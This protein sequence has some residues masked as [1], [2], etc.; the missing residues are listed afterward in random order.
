MSLAKALH[1]LRGLRMDGVVCFC[2]D[3]PALTEV[4]AA[5]ADPWAR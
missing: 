5:L 1:E 4:Q 3:G 2:G